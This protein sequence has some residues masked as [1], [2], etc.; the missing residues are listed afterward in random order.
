[1]KLSHSDIEKLL[2][3]DAADLGG[4]LTDNDGQ[5]ILYT[6]IYRWSD[7]SYNSEAEEIIS[8]SDPEHS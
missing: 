5:V 2:Q 8:E 6:G 1:M 4:C 7:G 3:Y